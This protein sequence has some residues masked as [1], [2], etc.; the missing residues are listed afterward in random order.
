MALKPF[1][2][3]WDYLRQ[4]SAASLQSFELSRLNHAANLRHEI[5]TLM[6]QWLEETAQAMLARWLLENRDQVR[7]SDTVESVSENPLPEA[8]SSAA[9]PKLVRAVRGKS[10]IAQ[11]RA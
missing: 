10:H 9:L 7:D 2:P 4:A 5:A 3:P 6:D 11:S 1:D 8:V